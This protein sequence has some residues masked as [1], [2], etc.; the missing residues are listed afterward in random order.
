[1]LRRR[2]LGRIYGYYDDGGDGSRSPPTLMQ[3]DISAFDPKAPPPKTAAFWAIVDANRP[4]EEG[5]LAD[6][7]DRMQN[8]KAF[9]LAAL[10]EAADGDARRL[11]ARPQE[12]P[13]HPAPPGEMRL[14]AGAQSRCRRRLVEDQR[15]A[16]GRLRPSVP[17]PLGA[18]QDLPGWRP[19]W[20]SRRSQWFF[21]APTSFAVLRPTRADFSQKARASRKK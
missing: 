10:Q 6:V 18:H 15:Q 8:P 21:H 14:R 7:I 1:M 3:R 20:S 13:H 5:E 9:T 4:S 11:A 12:P 19:G 16:P 17:A 2:L